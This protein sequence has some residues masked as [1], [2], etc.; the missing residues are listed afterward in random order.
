M[1]QKERIL[2]VDEEIPD[3]EDKEIAKEEENTP[4]QDPPSVLCLRNLVWFDEKGK[5]LFYFNGTF[6]CK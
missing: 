6:M 3:E 4:S 2:A 1:E 5:V